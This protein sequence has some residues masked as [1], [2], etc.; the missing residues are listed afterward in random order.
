MFWIVR[1]FKTGAERAP[2]PLEEAILRNYERK[3]EMVRLHEQTPGWLV[4]TEQRVPSALSYKYSDVKA[5]YVGRE[6]QHEATTA[7]LDMS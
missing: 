7:R 6:G 4:I 3:G 1:F 2:E 5:R